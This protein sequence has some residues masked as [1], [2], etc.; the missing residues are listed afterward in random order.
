MS[1]VHRRSR[2]GIFRI[3]VRATTCPD[4]AGPLQ[5]LLLLDQNIRTSGYASEFPMY[6]VPHKREIEFVGQF[7]KQIILLLLPRT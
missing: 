1:I 2:A 6:L 5:S 4:P 3:D 7:E